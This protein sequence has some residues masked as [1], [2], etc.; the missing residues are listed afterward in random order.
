MKRFILL[1]FTLVILVSCTTN[2]T[3]IPVITDTISATVENE[4]TVMTESAEDTAPVSSVSDLQAPMRMEKQYQITHLAQ[5]LPS[6]TGSNVYQFKDKLYQTAWNNDEEVRR[7]S[8]T[9][10]NADGTLDQIRYYAEPEAPLHY[11]P[12]YIFPLSDGCSIIMYLIQPD[13]S[14]FVGDAVA[15]FCILSEDGTVIH[16]AEIPEYG[17]HLRENSSAIPHV[18]ENEDG[19]FLIVF[20]V[21]SSSGFKL[22]RYDHNLEPMATVSLDNEQMGKFISLL[23]NGNLRTGLWLSDLT[24]IDMNYNTKRPLGGIRVPSY[25]KKANIVCAYT[26]ELYFTT[27]TDVYHCPQDGQPQKILCWTDTPFDYAKIKSSFEDMV[28]VMDDK[29]IFVRS[30]GSVNGAQKSGLFHIAITEVPSSDRTVIELAQ[31]GRAQNLWL[32]DMIYQFNQ[33]STEYKI[34]LTQY[35]TMSREEGRAQ[36]DSLLLAAHKPDIIFSASG[37]VLSRHNDKNAYLDLSDTLCVRLFGCVDRI[38][39]ENG[40]LYQL[41]LSMTATMFVSPNTVADQPLTWDMMEQIIH[42]LGD[43][44]LLTSSANAAKIILYPNT[45]MQFVNESNKES[46]FDSDAFCQAIRLLDEMNDY[47]DEAAGQ[48]TNNFMLTSGAYAITN[49]T[50]HRRLADGGIKLIRFDFS[51]LESYAALKLLFH[52]IPFTL[53]GL[54]TVTGELCADI[55]TQKMLSVSADTDAKEGCLAF[56]ELLL[57]DDAQANLGQLEKNLPV[58]P[59]AMQKLM[60]TSRY[61]YYPKEIIH[62]LIEAPDT[63]LVFI[64]WHGV[65]KEYDLSYGNNAEK[66]DELF[67]ISSFT[68]EDERRITDFFDHCTS[69][70]T[71][72]ETVMKIVNEELAYWK[73]DARSLEDTGNIID[74]RVWIYLNE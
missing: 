58:T 45:P 6:Y 38:H 4:T 13:G 5:T 59:S 67:Y 57:S 18:F 39:A 11:V 63:G 35:P 66:A 61:Q 31:I 1:I 71:D 23:E 20:A 32:N 37:D 28:W 26:D 70:R 19:T 49:G 50:L 73:N 34:N 53:C 62:D 10:W 9:S 74:S 46:S 55:Q 36:V 14:L 41:P 3:N 42:N 24:Q 52:E 65:T 25:M 68:E 60:D 17:A 51:E 15:V 16:H 22:Y 27:D 69:Y 29:N 21:F 56:V 72:D 44:E 30:S 7:V 2:E 40:A 64:S 8:L 48:L 12:S 43:R 47:V 54:P 33:A